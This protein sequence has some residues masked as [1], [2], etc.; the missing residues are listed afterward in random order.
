MR[1]HDFTCE[2]GTVS[3]GIFVREN[4]SFQQTNIHKN[5]KVILSYKLT[6]T[7]LFHPYRLYEA[8]DP[9]V[10]WEVQ[11]KFSLE[12]ICALRM[13]RLLAMYYT[14]NVA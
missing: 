8:I 7:F 11:R 3:C 14:K 1:S 10:W 12:I 6:Q 2:F 9:F 13:N 4:T 5:Q